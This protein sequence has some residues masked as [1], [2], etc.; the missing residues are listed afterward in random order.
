[1]QN[2]IFTRPSYLKLNLRTH[3]LVFGDVGFPFF[4]EYPVPSYFTRLTFIALCNTIYKH[5]FFRIQPV[6]RVIKE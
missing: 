4:A 5:G 3:G 6:I 1:M 2:V